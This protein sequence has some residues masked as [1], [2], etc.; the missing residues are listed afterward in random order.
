MEQII[1]TILGVGLTMSPLVML[2]VETLKAPNVIPNRWL[3]WVSVGVGVALSMYMGLLMPDLGSS[4]AQLALS[5]VVAGTVA[6]GI[7]DQVNKGKDDT[8]PPLDLG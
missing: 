4:L 6:S 7:Y 8:Q 5:G 3:S 2:L 1:A